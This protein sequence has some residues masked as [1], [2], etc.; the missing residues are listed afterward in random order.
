[1]YCLDFYAVLILDGSISHR[2]LGAKQEV[3]HPQRFM[4]QCNTGTI[5][6]TNTSP[7]HSESHSD[8]A[9]VIHGSLWFSEFACDV[10]QHADLAAVVMQEGL[11]NVCLITPSMT[12]V[13]A[14]I[15]VTIPRKRKGNIQQ[16]EKA[17]GILWCILLRVSMGLDGVG[18]VQFRGAFGF[19][20]YA[21]V[22]RLCDTG[23]H[24]AH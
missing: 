3:F 19:S 9:S 1:M 14:K 10:A 6:F 7:F 12:T 17:K 21:K 23:H 4:G 15:D 24:P 20:G 13:R 11:S 22:F 8:F 5:R 2:G 18:W 16:H